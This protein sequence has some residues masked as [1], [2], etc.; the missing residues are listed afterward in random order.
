MSGEAALSAILAAARSGSDI[1]QTLYNAQFAASRV[2]D[3][4][5]GA[6]QIALIKDALGLMTNSNG[7]GPFGGPSMPPRNHTVF[8]VDENGY[9]Q[10]MTVILSER[11]PMPAVLYTDQQLNDW[12]AAHPAP[13]AYQYD[14]QVAAAWNEYTAGQTANAAPTTD[15]F[16]PGEAV[17]P[18]AVPLSI[19]ADGTITHGQPVNPT[20]SEADATIFGLPPLAVAVLAGLGIWAFSQS[21]K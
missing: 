3:L 17:A 11:N 15:P 13:I 10:T 8:F 9:D 1:G 5:A 18:S 6:R 21:S 16:T 19:N 7:L 14:P 12:L 2:S 4:A 20:H